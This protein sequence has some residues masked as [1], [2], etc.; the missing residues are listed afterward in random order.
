MPPGPPSKAGL[1][2]SAG[3]S[4]LGYHPHPMPMAINS[5]AYRGRPGC[6][7]CGFCA[8]GCAI[9]AKGSTAVTAV[10]DA[11][12]TGNCTLLAECCVVG[13]DTE[14]SGARA[15]AVRY[16]DASGAPQTLTA[17]H[18]LVAA[19]A[20]ETPRLLLASTSASHPDGLGNGSGLVGTHLMFHI[21]MSAIGVFAEEVRSYRGRVITHAMGDFTVTPPAAGAL[22]GG[23]VELGGAVH[24]VE[25]GTMYPWRLAKTLMTQGTYRRC[26][27][28]VGMI[29]EDAPVRENRVELDPG[30]RD[31]YGRPVARITYARHPA[32]QAL[33]DTYMPRL[34]EIARAAG[35]VDVMEIDFAVRDGA[36][37]TRH[38]HGTTRMGT[39]PASSVTD[40]WGRLHEVENV[41]ICDGGTWPTSGAF[42][43]TLTQQALALRT[44]AR[45]DALYPRP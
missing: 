8:I 9:N 22:R 37:Q 19:N 6:V 14:P 16:L 32:D 35:A 25:E 13:I 10:R 5:T 2:L 3:A 34:S 33:V 44:A 17:E 29:G 31:V 12:L 4:A 38:L 15:S 11:L 26:I 41:W 43:P 36:P 23:Y 20:I 24:P 42:N 18:I 30:A 39:D 7:N 28:A 21:V 1:V 45:I 27:A 40:P